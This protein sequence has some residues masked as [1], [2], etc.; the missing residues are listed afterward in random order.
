MQ[1]M[2]DENEGDRDG[3][4]TDD[5]N[6]EWEGGPEECVMAKS[7]ENE[8]SPNQGPKFMPWTS[9]NGSPASRAE[10]STPQV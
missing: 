6:E 8:P 4:E 3:E 9:I 1:F 10:P 5:D 7:L 2:D